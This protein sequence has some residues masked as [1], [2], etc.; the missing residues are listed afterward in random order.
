MAFK[1]LTITSL[2]T[3]YL[4]VN[5]ALANEFKD[6]IVELVFEGWPNFH[7]KV[8]GE[9][10]D[11]TLPTGLL[12]PLSDY[13]NIL[14]KAY[15]DIIKRKGLRSITEEERQAFEIVLKVK[16]G[17]SEI[18]GGLAEKFTQ[19]AARGMDRM[20]GTQLVVTVLGIAL[21]AAGAWSFSQYLEYRKDTHADEM[22]LDTQRRMLDSQDKLV[23]V[24]S[25]YA[26]QHTNLLKSVSDAE[27]VTY[28]QYQY[29]KNALDMLNKQ[30]RTKTKIE[31]RNG[32][33]YVTG[34]KRI[35]TGHRVDLISSD[36]R[37]NFSAKIID[38]TLNNEEIVKITSA[39]IGSVSLTLNVT[40]RTNGDEIVSANIVGINNMAN[41]EPITPPILAQLEDDLTDD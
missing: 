28:G 8:E 36:S 37:S 16:K 10:Y 14:L 23:S 2:D 12:R 6:D 21:L 38:D 33:Y 22:Q 15:A 7:L 20:N 30:G 26:T 9:R 34:I 19:L 29:D 40:V 25:D 13:Q 11:S 18:D 24:L 27:K 39:Y 1:T 5:Q 3:A 41:G 31:Q 4:C 32:S 35:K 17:S